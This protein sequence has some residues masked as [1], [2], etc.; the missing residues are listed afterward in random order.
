MQNQFVQEQ[1]AEERAGRGSE[2]GVNVVGGAR[3]A[4]VSFPHVHADWAHR[5]L[6]SELAEAEGGKTTMVGG[7]GAGGPT[8]M[9]GGA[10]GARGPWRCSLLR[11]EKRPQLLEGRD[12][13]PCTQLRTAQPY[14]RNSAPVIGASSFCFHRYT[15]QV[16]T[17]ELNGLA[18]ACT[19]NPYMPLSSLPFPPIPLCPIFRPPAQS[20]PERP[21]QVQNPLNVTSAQRHGRN[22]ACCASKSGR[23]IK[24]DSDFNPPIKSPL[25]PSNHPSSPLF[26]HPTTHQVPSSPIQPPIKS[27]LRPSNHPSSPLFAHPTTHQVPSSPIQPPI[28]SP[29]RPSNHPSSPLFAHPTTHQVPSSPIQPPIKSPL[30]PSNHPSSPL[31]AHPTTHQVPSSPIQPP[32]KSPLRPS[33]HPSSPLFA[34]PTT[35]QVPSPHRSPGGLDTALTALTR[36]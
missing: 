34:H 26:A 17:P 18:G 27:P 19:A 8:V 30:R 31:F 36:S 24:F 13:P 23:S 7:E 11:A 29:L 3:G 4:C 22:E 33:N 9:A 28:K 15:H 12:L 10:G 25:R 14:F 1:V 21:P 32:I 35:H 2:G 16:V 20:V 5:L 6:R